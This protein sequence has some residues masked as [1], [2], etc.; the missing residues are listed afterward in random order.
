MSDGQIYSFL[1][2]FLNTEKIEYSILVKLNIGEHC[3]RLRVT[4]IHC[5][6]TLIN[7]EPLKIYVH[8]A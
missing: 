7:N 5:D 4:Y 6:I 3:N 8:P 2:L 1:H